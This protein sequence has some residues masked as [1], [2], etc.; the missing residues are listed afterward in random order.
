MRTSI[1][2]LITVG[3]L[4]AASTSIAAPA[5]NIDSA[6]LNKE[7]P[8]QEVQ[9]IYGGRNYCWYWDAWRGPGWY[10][11]GYAWRRGYGWGGG[12]GWHGW[13]VAPRRGPVVRGGYGHGPY[14]GRGGW[15]GHWHH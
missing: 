12:H 8:L 11:C 2:A 9:F 7:S 4:V 1:A 14:G 3:I 5:G 13:A 6:G 15:G 10:W